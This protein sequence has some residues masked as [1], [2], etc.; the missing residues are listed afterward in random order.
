MK[1]NKWSSERLEMV[2]NHLFSQN[3]RGPLGCHLLS[4]LLPKSRFRG[5]GKKVFPKCKMTFKMMQNYPL[6]IF[7]AAVRPESLPGADLSTFSKVMFLLILGHQELFRASF[8]GFLG[9]FLGA[10]LGSRAGIIFPSFFLIFKL[11]KLHGGPKRALRWPRQPAYRPSFNHLFES[12]RPSQFQHVS[13]EGQ[14][15]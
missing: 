9:P 2:K 6:S 7:H 15:P 8:L 11:F 3:C 10:C 1:V 12:S 5:S 4:S 13:K 14:G